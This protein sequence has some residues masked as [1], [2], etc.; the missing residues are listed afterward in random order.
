MIT[1][2]NFTTLLSNLGF[3]KQRNSYSTFKENTQKDI[4][5]E[6]LETEIYTKRFE[7]L[8]CELKVD[9]ENKELI[10]PFGLI[11]NRE[12]TKNF[13][14]NENFVV[15][16]CVCHLLQQGYSPTHIELEKPMP[17]GHH[18]T[19]GFCDIIIKDNN[20]KPY[21][22][23]ECKTSGKEFDDSWKK[24]VLD[25][26]QLFNYYNSYRQAEFL[27]LYTSDFEDVCSSYTSHI[28]SMKDNEEYLLS[29]IKLLSFRKV[30]DENGGKDDY[31]KVW[32]ETYQQDFAT[33]GIF[34][35][36]IAAFHVGRQKYC[37]ND[38]QDVD[39]NA[40][41][42]KY[43]EFATILRQHNV[44]G[45]ENAFDKLV[46]LF[47]AKIV[48]ETTNPNELM[49]YWKGAAY[50][51]YFNFQDRLQKMYKDGMQK[52]LGETVTYIDNDTIKETFHL[53][54]NDPD[55]I[56]D[57]ILSYFRELK[58]FTNNDFAFLDVHNEQLFFQNAIILKKIVQMLQDIK[59][60]TASQNQFLG[61]LFEGFLDQG[62]KQ[63]EGQFFTP[64][65][66]VKF[67]ISALPLENL[68][69]NSVEIPKA[70]DYACGAGHFLN[71]YAHQIKPFVEAHKADEIANYYAEITGIE[72]EYRLS[73]VAKVS[74]FMYGQDEIKIIY[75][76]ALAHNQSIK[77]KSYSVLVA[78]P[79][80][81]VK[82]FLETLSEKERNRF[83][84]INAIDTKQIISN[85]SIETFFIERAKQLLK[86]G[87]VAAII[88]PSSIL[89]NGNIYIKSR[90]IILKYFDL[91]AIA[92]FGSG[93]FGK[94]G[95]NTVTLFLRRKTDNP[96]TAEH[97]Q[98]R[99]NAWFK[100]D[101]RKDVIFE[102]SHLMSNYCN[103]I[104]INAENYKTLLSGRPD[105]TLLSTDI[106]K[107]YRKAFEDDAKA[108][109][110]KKKRITANYSEENK[111]D[112]LEKYI[113]GAIIAT[114]KEKLYY[115]LLAV[116]NPQPVLISKSPSDSK[117]MKQFLGYEWSGAKGSEGIKY[118]GTNVADEDDMISANK[119]INQIRTPLFNPNNFIATDKI[120]TLIRQNFNAEKVHI[121][122]SLIDLV[123]LTRLEDMIDFSRV[124]FDKSLRT[125]AMKN[126][127]IE[128]KYPLVKVSS[129]AMSI[130]AGGDKPTSYS[131]T[132]TKNY[133]IPIYAN[134][135]Q[136]NGLFGYTDIP[137][138]T[139]KCITISAR[140]TIGYSVVR[141]EP[142]VPIVRLIV[143][144]PN[145]KKIIAEF[146]QL[147]LNSLDYGNTGGVIPQL[148]VPYL[149]AVSIPLP[150][151]DIQHK[152][153]TECEKVN[154][155]YFTSKMSIEEN[156][157]KID[158]LC[159]SAYNQSNR[160]LKLSDR[161]IFEIS[162]GRRIVETELT[163]DGVIPVY[164]ANVIEPF[165]K[166]NKLLIEDF[167][168]P[169]VL[170]GIDGDWMVNQILANQ[171]FYPTDHCG[172]L[173]VKNGEV[174]P[175]YLMWA[176]N[177][178]G[179]EVR[180]SR[181][182]RASIDRVSALSINI[183]PL[184]IQQEI[185]SQ[186]DIYESEI[187]EAKQ[188]LEGVA[189]RKQAILDKW[190]K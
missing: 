89:S 37:I 179:Q 49:F 117:A 104:T 136:E 183:P 181:S 53:F 16:E 21:L 180:F 79:P 103:H 83:E 100:N 2:D 115:Y 150:P 185:V 38:L 62:V 149:S 168:Q 164:S 99:V 23:I 47:L 147:V 44:S 118:L 15:F 9:F 71:E 135:V 14:Q 92:E 72:K 133:Q 172:V 108:K 52:F 127:E 173:R 144:I 141:N 101:F 13:S 110:I 156:K 58:F 151:L 132:K 56:R 35:P 64:M 123:S 145:E 109:S 43:H 70:I 176:L 4:V 177:K 154:E 160:V 102:D 36:D 161:D 10:Y 157:I 27:C 91:L 120:N 60:K 125:S 158:K 84:L 97:L 12:T 48:D 155:E 190:L 8:N 187:A 119:G 68:I 116:S 182:H 3:T 34:E 138:V 107:E 146:F 113:L 105:E 139:E 45:R 22:L 171:P 106:F 186:I 42:K 31:F 153:V 20:E 98:N 82:G 148:T 1:K 76:D 80:Y 81:S 86:S 59:L 63:S 74:A 122:D 159:L 169:S 165:G 143:V 75:S 30:Q 5:S 19:G 95:T 188:V 57:K 69:K 124:S 121:P 130:T 184:S 167:S 28:I 170:W 73:K 134:G 77:D 178:V 33:S 131:K 94:T 137:K 65:P 140:G 51:D 67:L 128:S 111:Q 6:V 189:N 152:I 39:N 41:Q 174:L 90:E 18:D 54:K 66:I 17:G 25:G 162:I 93:T 61:D 112:E 55:A 87:G 78:N 96:D 50:D 175:H 46:N 114:E 166:I 163:A 142:F 88:L 24:M 29:D 32:K 129:I 126:I 7:S 40:I 11:A 26:G 85:N